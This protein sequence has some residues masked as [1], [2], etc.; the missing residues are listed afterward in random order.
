ML[1]R[2]PQ[3]PQT[4]HHDYRGTLRLDFIP[5][6]VPALTDLYTSARVCFQQKSIKGA[7]HVCF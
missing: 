5:E 4:T 3:R 2:H 1:Q 6:F 7:R